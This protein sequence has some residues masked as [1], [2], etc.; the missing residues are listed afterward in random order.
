MTRLTCRRYALASVA[1][2]LAVGLALGPRVPWL[3]GTA[4]SDYIVAHAPQIAFVRRAVAAWGVLPLWSPVYNA[5]YPL[6]ANPLASPAYP[7]GWLAYVLPLPWGLNLTLLLHL[8]WAVVGWGCWARGKGLRAWPWFGLVAGLL[9]KTLAHLLGGHVTLVYALAWFPWLLQAAEEPHHPGEGGEG[10][11]RGPDPLPSPLRKGGGAG[12]GGINTPNPGAASL[13]PYRSRAGGGGITDGPG[14]TRIAPAVIMALITLA[15]PRAAVLAG[16]L[17]AVAAW[18]GSWSRWAKDLLVWTALA[19]L[20]AAP[21]LLPLTVFTAVSTRGQMTFAERT[22][23]STPLHLVLDLWAA[24][25]YPPALAVEFRAYVPWGVSLLALAGGFRGRGR[26][27]L[28]LAGVAL[29][30]ALGRYGPLAPLWYVPG[31]TWLRVPA[32]FW[33]LAAF[34][35]LIAAG[36]AAAR[37]GPT[38]ATRGYRAFWLAWGVGGLLL[39]GLGWPVLFGVPRV[40][41][42]YALAVAADA[43]AWWLLRPGRSRVATRGLWALALVA[44]GATLTPYTAA[45]DLR[46][47]EAVDARL[48]DAVLHMAGGAAEPWAARWSGPRVYSPSYSIGQWTAARLGLPLAYGVDPLHTAAW[49]VWLAEASGVP[50]AGYSVVLPP[51]ADGDPRTAN[52]AYRADAA[53]LAEAR[54]AYLVAAFPQDAAGWRPRGRIAGQ[55][56]YENA[57]ACPAAWI[58][59]P[60]RPDCTAARPARVTSWTP[61]R[62]VVQAQG[63]GRLVLSEA[64]YPTWQVRVDGR[65]VA[66]EARGPWRAVTIP[67]GPHRVEWI[68]EAWDLALGWALAAWGG[69]ILLVTRMQPRGKGLRR[70]LSAGTRR[71]RNDPFADAR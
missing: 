12:G 6:Y 32:R 23:F 40:A 34:A 31:L 65:P 8:A 56:V 22:A 36:G 39:R 19:G 15:D 68:V 58:E 59:N 70:W 1:A 53:R 5:G 45:R 61:N 29:L 69:F 44:T 42:A 20:L 30:L 21:L 48:A 52:A 4:Y 24:L 27:W 57:Y 37:G 60:A 18:R 7:P 16:P 38:P 46:A 41:W 67:P 11:T 71:A 35:L 54:V 62:V 14:R 43:A 64:A 3:A 17:L 9:P 47:I 55:W 49:A 33:W 66:A 10:A 28:A 63:P 13:R 25:P 26:R 50:A 51:L 2:A